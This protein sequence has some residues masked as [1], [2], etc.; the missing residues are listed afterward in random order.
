VAEFEL[1]RSTSDRRVYELGALGSVRLEGLFSRRATATSAGVTWQLGP[2]GPFAQTI[3]ALSA[4]GAVVGEFDPG[5]SE[6]RWKG[7]PFQLR[8]A[9]SQPP[10][11]ALVAGDAEVAVF[12]GGPWGTRP[13]KV[14]ILR[15]E[16]IEPALMLFTAF[17]VRGTAER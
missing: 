6:L 3:C 5:S 4:G 14:E 8:P 13:R 2:S 9:S 7:R 11:F 1:T 17:V 12:E 15:P 10:R 16:A